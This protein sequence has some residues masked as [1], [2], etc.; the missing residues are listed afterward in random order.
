M[1]N[2]FY[3]LFLLVIGFSQV[4]AQQYAQLRGQ[5]VD[6]QTGE[7][8]IGA[9]V[10][11][12]GTAIGA[13]SDFEGRYKLTG[14]KPGKYTVKATY[15]S[16]EATS[17]TDVS[18]KE[19]DIIELNIALAQISLQMEQVT[20]VAQSERSFEAALLNQRRK[21]LSIHDAIGAEQIKRTTDATVADALRRVPG[22]TISENKFVVLRGLSE[23]YSTAMLNNA[24]LASTEPDKKS[25]AL[26]LIP[27]NL[28]ENALVIKS[29]SLDHPADFGSGLISINTVDFP[30]KASLNL[31]YGSSFISG[32]TGG[33]VFTY[34]GGKKDFLGIDDGTRSLPSGFTENIESISQDPVK[35]FNEA[36]LLKNSWRTFTKTAP[37]NQNISLGYGDNFSVFGNE[38]GLLASFSYKTGYSSSSITRRELMK[39]MTS[40]GK[41]SERFN[42]S[43]TQS[44]VSVLWGA[45]LNTSYRIDEFNKISLK[46]S[47]TVNSDDEV[48][49]LKGW[50]Y[51]QSSY[52]QNTGIR[53]VSRQLYSGQLSGESY[54]PELS[55]LHIQYQASFSES[56]R[57]EPDYRRYAY[58]LD[59]DTDDPLYMIMSADVSPQLAGRYFSNLFEKNKM[60]GINFKLPLSEAT[61]K[62][63]GSIVGKNRN[64]ASRLIGIVSQPNTKIQLLK[65][66]IDTIFAEKN[67]RYGSGFSVKEYLNGTNSYGTVETIRALYAMAELPFSIGAMNFVSTFGIRVESWN[68]GLSTF[69][70]DITTLPVRIDRDETGYFP[71][72][73]LVYRMSEQ[74]NIK[75]SFSR[76][77]NRPEFRETAPFT[78]YDFQNQISTRGDTSV[79]S[80]KISSYDIRYEMFPRPGEIISASIFYKEI[81]DAIETVIL[82]GS[83]AE[84]SFR[85]APLARNI[86]VEFENRINLDQISEYLKDFS[87]TGNYAWIQSEITETRVD[88]NGT[89]H[90]IRRPLQGQAP[91]TVNISLMYTNPEWGTGLAV[92]YY[93]NG[94]KIIE[95][96]DP[97]DQRSISD[98]YEQGRPILD[99][100][101][102][103]RIGSYF[104][105]KFSVKDILARDQKQTLL[106]ETVRSSSKN[107]QYGVGISVK[108]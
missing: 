17:I 101:G 39:Q 80:A 67:F 30:A 14:I 66:G 42:F 43:G 3:T 57:Q 106:N 60:A 37:L 102:T 26:D 13:V 36:K 19:S 48:T 8:L 69:R 16:Y 2:T 25:F 107:V 9:T 23:R 38:L 54:L 78:Y 18:F 44:S 28:I 95:T 45:L 97:N 105:V 55:G 84:R 89:A 73:T 93:E 24:A 76:T 99:F 58:E 75:A 33:N 65:Y 87:M 98:I 49:S 10:V 53:F 64:F 68:S 82:P 12:Q 56:G 83:N 46:N 91:F 6:K 70:E 7:R 4:H 34:S 71:A 85:N 35:L 63:G 29:Y 40:D 47:F 51:D 88:D 32:V 72:A 74:T 20:V 61:I 21:S 62:F 59:P 31:S 52:R 104:E 103:Q 100:T 90:T 41:Y 81:V 94:K 11:L 22:L 27:A 50:Q 86:G 5:I 1:K 92:S 77:T 96:A 79:G 108:L 15:V